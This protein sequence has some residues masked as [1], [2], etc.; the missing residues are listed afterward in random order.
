M[1]KKGIQPLEL[2][3]LCELLHGKFDDHI[4][5][6]GSGDTA[7]ERNFFSKAL[8]AYYLVSELAPPLKMLY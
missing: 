2:I 1:A 5:S 6:T 8:A 4:T 7:K 3:Q